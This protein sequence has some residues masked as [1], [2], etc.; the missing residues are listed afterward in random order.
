MQDN[1]P[2]MFEKKCAECG[3]TFVSAPEH[4]FKIGNSWFC[5]WTCYN[6]YKQRHPEIGVK[7][8]VKQK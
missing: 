4:I 3:K 6:H 8:S 5:K 7:R 1:Y 2:M